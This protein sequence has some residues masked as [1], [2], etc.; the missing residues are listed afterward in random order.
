MAPFV[1]DVRNTDD[2][3]DVVHR[4]VQA[5]AEGR[6]VALPTE[7]VYGLAASA[8]D[9]S[10]VAR[11][12]ELKQRSSN[13]PLT[14]AVKSADEALDYIPDIPPLGRRLA[15]RCWPGPVTLVLGDDHPDSL[16]RK[17]PADVQRAVSSKGWVGL[18]V[19]AHP[20]VLDILRLLVGPLALSSANLSG[21]P[22]AV[23]AQEVV[24]SFGDEVSL[25]L[26][27]GKSKFAQP[28]SVVRVDRNQIELLRSG[29]VN[30]AALK[31]LSNFLILL[32]CTG[33]TCRSPM[34]EMLMGRK[35]AGQLGCEISEL[36]DRGVNVLSAGIAAV[37]GGKP[38]LEAVNVMGERGLDL[39]HHES[40]PLSDRLVRHADVIFTMTQS[41]RAA[42]VARWPEASNRIELLCPD[43]TDVADPIGG[44]TDAY[45]SCADQID[46]HVE[47]RLKDLD[48]VAMVGKVVNES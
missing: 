10:A 18:R 1:I 9:S 29:V 35:I 37:M 30:V 2:R 11:M 31:R 25:V 22:D 7:T 38:S 27:D 8:R 33:N 16:L 20:L 24:S 4:A 3:R 12:Y 32:V 47:A 44:P 42:V 23:T 34:A 21:Q 45:R 28:S 13:V 43:G 15:R 40:Q 19:P 5:L 41:H 39:T 48:V 17:L 26:D 14:L 46:V 6:L 36:N